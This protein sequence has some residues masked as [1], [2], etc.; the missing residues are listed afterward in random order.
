[1]PRKLDV[2]QRPLDIARKDSAMK[3]SVTAPCRVDLA[4]GTLDIWPLGLL[5]RGS[6]TVNVA[7]PTRVRMEVELAGPIGHVEHAE[8]NGPWR[9]L[10]PED[11]AHDLTA[12]V[13][14]ALRSTGGVRVRVLEQAPIGSGLGGSSSYAVALARA[15][16][17]LEER[18]MG[19]RALVAL[20]RDLEARVL[21]IPTGTQDHWAAIR[22]GVLAVHIEPG[23]E[24]IER[25]QV[26]PEWV[27]ERLTVFF[28]GINHH[29]GMVNWEV[30]RRRLD[31]DESTRSAL[32]S[33]ADAARLCRQALVAQDEHELGAAVSAEWAARR[34]LAPDVCPDDVENVVR[35]AQIAG[36]TAVKACGAGGGGSLLL[37][38]PPELRDR[39][40]D[41]L[42][43]VAPSGRVLNSGVARD[44]CE[45]LQVEPSPA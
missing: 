44:G 37:W 18:L 38:H 36:A 2:G 17:A 25:L 24:S 45:V 10:G 40:T 39:V 5:H 8:E 29:S 7:I 42:I 34:R 32:E 33:I 28:T 26:D 1:V 23:G 35:H 4:G 6:L 43:S 27:S 3:V 31:G 20:L 12:A 9:M 15:V 16:L 41:A 21:G 30:I 22:G 14:F 19:D 11:T 13:C